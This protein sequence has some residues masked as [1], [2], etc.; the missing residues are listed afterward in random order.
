MIV[1]IPSIYRDFKS[2]I[3]FP[4]EIEFFTKYPV[5][6]PR[7]RGH[8]ENITARIDSAFPFYIAAHTRDLSSRNVLAGQDRIQRRPQI[9]SRNWRIALRPA[10]VHLAPVHQFLIPSEQKKSG[11]HAAAYARAT[12]WV[13]S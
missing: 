12:S 7:L 5:P 9:R 13:A 2:K 8:A 1:E 4:L 11:V 10:L 6:C 3:T